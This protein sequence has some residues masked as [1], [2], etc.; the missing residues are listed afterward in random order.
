[1]LERNL[2]HFY[3]GFQN[4]DFPDWAFVH[5]MQAMYRHQFNDIL[6]LENP[7]TTKTQLDTLQKIL[8]INEGMLEVKN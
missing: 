7:Y 8:K 3:R 1:M 6:R 2:P 4:G 5:Y